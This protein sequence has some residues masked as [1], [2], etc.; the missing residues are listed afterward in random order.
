[1]GADGGGY[2]RGLLVHHY[3]V[4]LT[5]VEWVQAGVDQPGA[6]KR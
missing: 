1:M 5:A 6:R 3:G 2:S 4:P